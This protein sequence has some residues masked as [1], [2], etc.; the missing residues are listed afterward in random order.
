MKYYVLYSYDDGYEWDLEEYE[1]LDEAK[2][3]ITVW[4]KAHQNENEPK[5]EKVIYG[6]EL[7]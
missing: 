7:R 5:V 1:T 4:L 3:G 2:A 6:E